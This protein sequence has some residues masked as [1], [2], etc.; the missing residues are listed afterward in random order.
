MTGYI[1]EKVQ[2]SKLNYTY[3]TVTVIF[4]LI[5]KAFPLP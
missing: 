5:V 4:E 2:I 1:F 3:R